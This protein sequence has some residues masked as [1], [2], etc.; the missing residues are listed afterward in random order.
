MKAAGKRQKGARLERKIAELIRASGLDKKAKRSFQSGAHWSWKSDIYTKIPFSIESKCQER[1]NF[2]EWWEQAEANSKPMRPP[3][4]VHSAN[5]R[6]I[7][8]SMKFETFLDVLKE[9]EDWK[10]KAKE[11]ERR[12]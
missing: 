2:W 11:F 9:L 5:F 10:N 3:I 7:M 4:L 1:M 8:V 6:P 12:K